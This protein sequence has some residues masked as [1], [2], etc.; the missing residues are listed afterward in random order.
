MEVIARKGYSN[1]VIHKDDNKSQVVG[2]IDKK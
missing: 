2:K 1:I